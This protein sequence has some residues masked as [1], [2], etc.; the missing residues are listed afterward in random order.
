MAVKKGTGL[1]LSLRVQRCA[2][3]PEPPIR[4][5]GAHL[6]L[7]RGRPT[8]SKEAWNSKTKSLPG[9]KPKG[10]LRRD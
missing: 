1:I 5:F 2:D 6:A 7:I 8:G 9:P 10:A 3:G 4:L